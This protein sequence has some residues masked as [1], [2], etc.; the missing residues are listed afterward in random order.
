[1]QK[2]IDA[3]AVAVDDLKVKVGEAIT[4]IH[5]LA[6]QL[7]E[8]AGEDAKVADLTAKIK[9]QADVLHVAVFPPSAAV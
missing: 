2:E 9:E 3:L 5:S 7:A 4:E 1:M 6:D 8:H